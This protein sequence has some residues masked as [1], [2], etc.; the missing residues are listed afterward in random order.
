VRPAPEHNVIQRPE[1]LRRLQRFLGLRQ[2]HIAPALSEGVQPVVI[3]GNVSDS[4]GDERGGVASAEGVSTSDASNL[5]CATFNNPVTSGIRARILWF[6]IEPLAL[7]ATPSA[8]DV[9]WALSFD[10]FGVPA[11]Q[12]LAPDS[13]GARWQDG[14]LREA[15]VV[16]V[17]PSGFNVAG[18]PKDRGRPRASLYVGKMPS[19][20]LLNVGNLYHP[21]LEA[22]GARAHVEISPPSVWV[23]PSQAITFTVG[24]FNQAGNSFNLQVAWS[25][26]PI[27]PG[28]GLP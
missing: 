11:S 8:F 10:L 23:Y 1:L 4:P 15:Y 13:L 26:E 19:G 28:E 20:S 7:V 24:N 16:T 25:E 3:L 21:Y 17:P 6:A 18:W 14:N 9:R 27:G 12:L 5:A 2:A 22:T